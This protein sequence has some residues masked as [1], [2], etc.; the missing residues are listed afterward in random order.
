[1]RR[2]RVIVLTVLLF[3]GA[4]GVSPAGAQ[5]DDEKQLYREGKK[6]FRSCAAC[7][8][9]SEP[10]LVE[11]EDWLQLNWVTRC[12]SAGEQTPRVRKALD[13]FFRSPKTRRPLLVT[14]AYK[15]D[16]DRASGTIKVPV[17]SGSVYLKAERESIR[18][19]TPAK[20][21]LYWNAS[22]N[23]QTLAVPAGKYRVIT[24]RFYH[25][26]TDELWTLSVSDVNGC[27]DVEVIDGENLDL[28]FAPEISAE[29]TSERT[30]DG[31]ALHL[32]MRNQTGS[33][34]TVSIDGNMH[35]PR[36]RIKDVAGRQIYSDVYENT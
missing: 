21:R 30:D 34:L 20:V 33:T 13:V 24:Y 28:P 18:G 5:D 2:Y 12:I 32:G 25:Q 8:C 6:A 9:V 11:D 4:L 16:E 36:F 35:L 27:A 14:A 7:H 17:T 26:R 22:E 1:M 29:L 19:G 31:L 10:A 23:G 3:A 15:P